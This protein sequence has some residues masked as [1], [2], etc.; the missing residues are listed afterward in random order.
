MSGQLDMQGDWAW[1]QEDRLFLRTL[2]EL[3]LQSEAWFKFSRPEEVSIDWHRTENQGQI[4][5]CQG[6]SVSSTLERLCQVNGELVQLSEIFA[7]LGTQKIDGLLGSDR[8]STISGGCKLAVEVGCCLEELTGYPRSYPDRAAREKILSPANYAAA[9]RY[10]AKSAWKVPDDHDALLNFIGGGGGVN[11]GISYYSGLIPKDRVV[12]SFRPGAGGGGH[13]MC[14]LG[15]DRDGN[16][17]AANSH[18]DGPYLITPQAWKQMLAHRYTAAIGL[19][20]N[21]EGKPVNWY[22]NS[23]YYKLREKAD[24]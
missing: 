3:P 12:R 15:Y 18:A 13:A 7:Y 21:V 6:H 11:F 2:A 1:E 8:G 5:S 10:K 4:G 16:L 14:V 23:P 24:E 22:E 20:G 9:A 17:R 19:M